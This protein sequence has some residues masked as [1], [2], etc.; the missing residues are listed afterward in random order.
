MTDNPLSKQA[1]Q[2][3]GV[4]I[5]F[6]SIV[7]MLLMIVP[8]YV[9]SLGAGKTEIGMIMGVTMMA[10]MLARPVA[11]TLIDRYGP[12][13][14]FVTAL[15]VFALSLCA[16]FVPDL[17]VIGGVRLI[18]GVA[19]ALFSTAMEIITIKL[20]T[21]RVRGQGLSLYSLATVLP[22]T[23]GPALALYLKDVMPMPWIFSLFMMMG[24]CTFVYALLISRQPH[25]SAAQGG[26]DAG[27]FFAP[28]QWRNRCLIASSLTMLCASVA[29]GAIFTF[30]PLHLEAIHSP[31]GS[32]YF[33][34]QTIVLVT[35]RFVGRSWVPSDGSAPT[36]LLLIT[37]LLAA[38]GTLLLAL[39]ASLPLLLLAALCN[40]VAFA[41]LYPALLTF[42]SFAV[43]EQSRAFLLALFIAAADLGF[44]LGALAMGPLA[45]RFSYQAMYLTCAALCV[46][47]SLVFIVGNRNGAVVLAERNPA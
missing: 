41:L 38:S 18:Q 45:D 16:Y 21:E 37:T 27:S 14:I 44:A 15:L 1:A 9:V 13:P 34:T 36:L 5:L 12:G 19:A 28:G 33:L 20:L 31:Y 35:C 17:W 39:T 46:V 23:F 24:A 40:G 22:T 3:Y 2:V 26:Q 30:L 8:F 32:L 25:L 7:Y 10:S 6:Y 42:V 4:T 47:G 11:G 29:N 43:P